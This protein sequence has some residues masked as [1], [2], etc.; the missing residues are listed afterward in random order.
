MN[1]TLKMYGSIGSEIMNR[2]FVVAISIS[3]VNQDGVD[4]K[5]SIGKVIPIAFLV[6]RSFIVKSSGLHLLRSLRT[7]N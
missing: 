5:R 3:N 4:C 2:C 6:S 1:D 7:C